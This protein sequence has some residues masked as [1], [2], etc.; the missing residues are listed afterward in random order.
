MLNLIQLLRVST[1]PCRGLRPPTY[2]YMAPVGRHSQSPTF[3]SLGAEPDSTFAR[4]NR[5]MSGSST[6]DLRIHGS[7]R[8]ALEESDVCEFGRYLIQHLRVSPAPCRG[9]RPPTCEYMALVGRHSKSPTSARLGADPES[10]FAGFASPMSGSLT[11]DLRMHGS[12]RSAL[13]ESDVCELGR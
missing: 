8:S 4:F 3:V 7:R 6:T 1:D 11:T 13:A 12:R 5:P 9:L 2:E 10:T